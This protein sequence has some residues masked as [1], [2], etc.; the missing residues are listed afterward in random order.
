[1]IDYLFI[2]RINAVA[3]Y[4]LTSETVSIFHSH[5]F[6]SVVS[7]I[8]TEF[9]QP[10]PSFPLPDT[11]AIR[12]VSFSE[13]SEYLLVPAGP[14]AWILA[15]QK[16]NGAVPGL[17]PTLSPAWKPP[18]SHG[19]GATPESLFYILLPFPYPL[20]KVTPLQ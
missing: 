8:I 20:S 2:N 13:R 15:N 18:T 19:Q 5:P 17:E 7:C 10:L 1:M 12:D 11:V 9:T 3:L 16:I 14:L 6:P 4:T